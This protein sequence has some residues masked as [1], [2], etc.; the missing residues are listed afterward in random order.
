MW[1]RTKWGGSYSYK[2]C[3]RLVDISCHWLL[4]HCPHLYDLQNI[5]LGVDISCKLLSTQNFM[6]IV[7][8]TLKIHLFLRGFNRP[9]GMHENGVF[10]NLSKFC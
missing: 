2:G 5:L 4:P 1:V 8:F 10:T 6:C 7:K 9:D 3:G